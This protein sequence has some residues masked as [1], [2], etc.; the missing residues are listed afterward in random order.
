MQK[1]RME[2]GKRGRER[3]RSM[4][5]GRRQGC[6]RRRGR[7]RR[8]KGMVWAKDIPGEEARLRA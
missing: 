3:R 4:E 8:E 7:R 6:G 5:G 1:E 2:T